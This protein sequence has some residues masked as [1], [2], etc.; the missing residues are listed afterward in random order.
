MCRCVIYQHRQL[1][2]RR[3]R[4]YSSQTVTITA[5]VFD[6]DGI[7]FD[8]ERLSFETFKQA[9]EEAGYEVSHEAFL[10]S[11]G[12]PRRNI[13]P[14]LA[15]V[16]GATFPA[17]QVLDRSYELLES[18][19]ERHGPPLKAGVEE[20]LDALGERSIPM[21]VATSTDTATARAYLDTA[22]LLT[23]STIPAF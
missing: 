20:I 15:E 9:S 2:R 16:L 17:T 21:I 14:K 19:V 10:A 13:P 5:A 22:G 12:L 18:A 7:I 3:G 11:M 8:T 4:C 6:M 1:D 23:Q